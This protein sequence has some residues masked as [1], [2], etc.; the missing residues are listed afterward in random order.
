MTINARNEDDVESSLIL[1]KVAKSSGA[2]CQSVCVCVCHRYVR[3][4]FQFS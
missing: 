3:C 4:Q 2:V 1:D